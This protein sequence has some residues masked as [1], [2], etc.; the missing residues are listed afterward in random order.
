[1]RAASFPFSS[2]LPRK[3]PARIQVTQ[4]IIFPPT[5]T[6]AITFHTHTHTHT[7]QG[8]DLVD[9]C[10]GL[11]PVGSAIYTGGN[12]PLAKPQ[13]TWAC[14]LETL[15]SSGLF[16]LD[17]RFFSLFSSPLNGGHPPTIMSRG[18]TSSIRSP[19]HPSSDS[20]PF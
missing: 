10:H 8:S 20:D 5:T 1:M 3:A 6:T 16:P 14:F 17:T 9:A 11:S 7:Q 2:P 19:P 18:S 13:R 15:F 4:T 12:E